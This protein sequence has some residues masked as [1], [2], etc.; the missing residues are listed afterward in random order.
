M[1]NIRF[2]ILFPIEVLSF[3]L[4]WLSFFTTDLLGVCFWGIL[5]L[6]LQIETNRILDKIVKGEK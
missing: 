1:N 2:M 5:M 3:V 6:S 4:F